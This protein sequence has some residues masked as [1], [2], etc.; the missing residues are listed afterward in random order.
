MA[1]EQRTIDPKLAAVKKRLAACK[2][3]MTTF[4]DPWQA[5]TDV[6]YLLRVIGRRVTRRTRINGGRCRCL[7]CGAGSEWIESI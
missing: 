6:D 7:R 3:D 2:K 4:R 1:N 5:V